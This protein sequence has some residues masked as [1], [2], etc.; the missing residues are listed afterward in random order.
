MSAREPEEFP[1]GIKKIEA[2]NKDTIN[3]R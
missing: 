2:I 1:S 3:I